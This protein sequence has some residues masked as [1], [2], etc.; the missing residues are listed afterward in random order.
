MFGPQ[1]AQQRPERHGQRLEGGDTA[2]PQRISTGVRQQLR[3]QYRPGRWRFD[4]RH[5]GVPVV[6]V[7]RIIVMGIQHDDL[8]HAFRMG[9]DR[10]N[11]QITEAQG[12]RTL[13]LRVIACSRR[14]TT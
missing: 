12:Q 2:G 9:I 7:R 10:V 8:L 4:K 11:M 1:P 13:L 5:V 14:N 3:R 6:V